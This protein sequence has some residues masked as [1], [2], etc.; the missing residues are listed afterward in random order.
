MLSR[1]A[2]IHGRLR[3]FLDGQNRDSKWNSTDKKFLLEK[4]LNNEIQQV[5]ALNL[6]GVPKANVS[7]WCKAAKSGNTD[8][9]DPGR[10]RDLNDEQLENLKQNI[11]G[12]RA[13]V[14][15]QRFGRFKNKINEEINKGYVARNKPPFYAGISD[16]QMRR[17]KDAE[18][19]SVTDKAQV[20]THARED[21][22]SDPRNFYAEACM[23]EA[24]S[25]DLPDLHKR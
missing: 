3:R 12:N 21:N 17:L 24:F 10:P 19:A 11:K 16:R 1:S 18:N 23:L 2:S 8:F 22:E 6:Y 4:V 7:R 13:K 25:K 20:A 15:S 14:N 9:F 5:D